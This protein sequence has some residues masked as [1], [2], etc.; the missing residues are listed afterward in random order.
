MK[1]H[2]QQAAASCQ[3][4]RV[5]DCFFAAYV[6]NVLYQGKSQGNKNGVNNPVE[7]MGE[8]TAAP[9]NKNK[10]DKFPA[11]LNQ[12][13]AQEI[14]GNNKGKRVSE[15][16]KQHAFGHEFANHG[17]H[18]GNAAA[19]AKKQ[20]QPQ[21]FAFNAILAINVNHKHQCWQNGK[22]KKEVI[23]R[24]AFSCGFRNWQMYLWHS[25]EKEPPLRMKDGSLKTCA[26]VQRVVQGEA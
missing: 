21:G 13:N 5:A 20:K 16:G 22:D 18:H 19:Q 15:R 3:C 2:T 17:G 4:N 24:S 6:K 7:E 12:S 9:G 14:V 26:V 8:T 11:F 10:E 1:R 23:H 25:I